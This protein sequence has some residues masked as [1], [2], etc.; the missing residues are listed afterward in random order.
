VN[1]LIPGLGV[2]VFG[3]AGA[4]WRI[5]YLRLVRKVFKDTGDPDVLKYAKAVFDRPPLLG[6]PPDATRDPPPPT[7]RWS[8]VASWLRSWL[9]ARRRR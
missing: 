8:G 6:S 5:Y 9:S 4:A 1:E 2:G 7:S 3:A